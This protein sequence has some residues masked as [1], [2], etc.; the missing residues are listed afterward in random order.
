[1]AVNS[2]FPSRCLQSTTFSALRS[3]SSSEQSGCASSSSVC[4]PS[5]DAIILAHRV[6]QSVGSAI[7][8]IS[9]YWDDSPRVPGSPNTAWLL[10]LFC[11]FRGLCTWTETFRLLCEFTDYALNSLKHN[12]SQHSASPLT[13]HNEALRWLPHFADDSTTRCSSN[14]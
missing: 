13:A 2:A 9:I 12:A 10:Y 7:S 11:I 8:S 6:S 1:M 3:A 5:K 14:N 4:L